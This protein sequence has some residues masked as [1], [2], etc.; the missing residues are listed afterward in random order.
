MTAAVPA[1]REPSLL[2]GF[3]L[4]LGFTLFYVSGLVLLP[5]T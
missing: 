3:G 4:T 1:A 5:L 2:P